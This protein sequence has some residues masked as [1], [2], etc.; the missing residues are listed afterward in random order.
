MINYLKLVDFEVKRF[1]KIYA[2]LI[3]LLF[4]LQPVAMFFSLSGVEENMRNTGVGYINDVMPMSNYTSSLLF[5]LPNIICIGAL[6][7]YV[8]GTW[9]LEWFGKNTFAYQILLLP[10]NRM[11]VYF[12]KLTSL[13]LFIIGCIAAQLAI[14]PVLKG[15]YTFRIPLELRAG[16]NLISWISQHQLILDVVIPVNGLNFIGFYSLGIMSVIMIF[17]MIVLERS[18]R[19]KGIGLSILYAIGCVF[20][21]IV[22]DLIDELILSLYMNEYVIIRTVCVAITIGLSLWISHYAINKKISV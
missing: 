5:I 15:I 20:L 1:W 21:F 13:L 2:V 22:A 11:S 12:A 6:L 18:F 17:T 7:F 14:F 16:D 3:A 4:V 9:Y 8:F 19:L 10:G